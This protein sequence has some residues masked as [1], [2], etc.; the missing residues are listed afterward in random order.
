VRGATSIE[1]DENAFK[2]VKKGASC[3]RTVKC[4]GST[5]NRGGVFVLQRKENG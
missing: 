3:N 2:Q 5:E 1:S 4:A